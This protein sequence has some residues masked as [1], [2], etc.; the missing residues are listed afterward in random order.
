MKTVENV[1]EVLGVVQT[2]LLAQLRRGGVPLGETEISSVMRKLWLEAKNN[3]KGAAADPGE[4]F[5]SFQARSSKQAKGDIQGVVETLNVDAP[6]KEPAAAAAKP[7]GGG[8][9]QDGA[10]A[11]WQ[12]FGIIL[13]SPFLDKIEQGKEVGVTDVPGVFVPIWETILEMLAGEENMSKC[14]GKCGKLVTQLEGSK[15]KTPSQLKDMVFDDDISFKALSYVFSKVIMRF[16]KFEKRKEWFVRMV[17][18][19][20][21]E[22]SVPNLRG[23]GGSEWEFTDEAFVKLFRAIMVDEASNRPNALMDRVTELVWKQ[24]DTKGIKVATGF[25]KSLGAERKSSRS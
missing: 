11:S 19:E 9:E 21:E 7:A 20:L 13:A 12:G 24:H 5:E 16:E 1:H 6:K 23:G 4:S 2:A 15:W 17:N 25:L 22:Y 8:V 3:G 18:E 14:R 10:T